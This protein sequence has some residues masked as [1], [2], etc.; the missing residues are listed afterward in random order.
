MQL[1][2]KIKPFKAL[3]T[4]ELYELL[5]L[6]N[7][8]FIVE[9]NCV[10]QDLD[11]KDQIAIHIMGELDNKIIAYCRI[12]KP[13]DYFTEAA[14]GRVVLDMNFRNKKMGHQL[15]QVAIETIQSH[16]NERN[17][18]ISAQLYL[19]HFYESHGFIQSS[20]EYLEDGI[21]HIEMKIEH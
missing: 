17:I 2:W 16:F 11:E 19:K 21:P 14:I 18:T 9:Q 7:K 4:I 10:Y 8:V 3:S 1:Q 13:N 20:E 6:R 15:M 5:Q 12:F